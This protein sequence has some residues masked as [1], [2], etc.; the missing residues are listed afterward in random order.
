MPDEITFQNDPV[1][2]SVEFRKQHN[3]F[4]VAER[5][6]RVDPDRAAGELLWKRTSLVQRVSYH[7]VTLQLEDYAV[8][9]DM[10]E[11]EYLD[12]Q[13]FPFALDFISPRCVRLRVAVRPGELG[14]GAS[15]MLARCPPGQLWE[16]E[17]D[18]DRTTWRGE[19]GSVS[20]R[21]DP[22]AFELRDTHG[23]ILTR[24]HHHTESPGVVNVNWYVSSWFS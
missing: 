18:R 21:R 14:V 10:P 8:W 22:W 20:V 4:F 13:A 12:E 1:D 2:P 16:R 11:E 23:R 9:R 19:H 17:D 6:E 5:A 15:L 24:T 7:Q 3:H